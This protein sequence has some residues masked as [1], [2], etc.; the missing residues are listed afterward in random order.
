MP[1]G[2]RIQKLRDTESRRSFAERIG[3]VENTLRNYE[4]GLSL[5]NSDVIANICRT[6][7]VRSEWLL[8]DVGDPYDPD[9][10]ETMRP[11]CGDLRC[12]ERMADIV[13]RPEAQVDLERQA[14]LEAK[15]AALEKELAEARIAESRAKDEALRAYKL[16]VD[17]MRPATLTHQVGLSEEAT[18]L[19]IPVLQRKGSP[20]PPHQQE[21]LNAK[22]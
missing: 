16:A 20:H 6:L 9:K 17:A 1:I 7:G 4:Q 12:G 13:L 22:K 19:D 10:T 18:P 3:I 2:E 8:F 21:P 14:V 15:I 11:G 5:P